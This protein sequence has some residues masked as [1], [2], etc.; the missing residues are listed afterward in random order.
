MLASY[1]ELLQAS[2]SLLVPIEVKEC[3]RMIFNRRYKALIDNA[4]SD[5]YLSALFLDPGEPAS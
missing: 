3:I 2:S 4:P 5:C 1:E